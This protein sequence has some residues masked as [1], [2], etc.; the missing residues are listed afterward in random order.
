ME[1]SIDAD[2]ISEQIN[3]FKIAVL[4]DL[5]TFSAKACN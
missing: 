5:V 4:I 1:I 3:K 2:F